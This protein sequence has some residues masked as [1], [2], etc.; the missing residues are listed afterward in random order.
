MKILICSD[1]HAN[2]QAIQ[3]LTPFLGDVDKR[4]CLGDIVG[5]GCAVNECIDYLRENQFI[6]IQGNHERYLLEGTI[7]QTKY[8]NESVLFGIEI[9][10]QHIASENL[11]WISS[12]PISLGI[13][14]DNK[15]LL[16]THGSP[17]DPID[18]YIYENTLYP[19]RFSMLK[20]DIISIGHTHRQLTFINDKQIIINPGSIG[21]AR[22]Y[23]G[24]SCFITLDTKDGTI[25][26]YKIP[27]NY[28]AHLDLS[29]KKGGGEW[30]YKHFKRIKNFQKYDTI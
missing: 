5:Y 4:V 9:A 14:V 13:L 27:Y 16:L 2:F 15:R 24:Y 11:D 28:S 1:I 23:E 19:Q 29:K 22:D 26:Q 21:Q 7:N 18:E 6:C 25:D 8:L 3:T 20:Y 12:L 10:K 30:I 17:F